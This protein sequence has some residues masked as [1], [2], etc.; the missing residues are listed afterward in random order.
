MEAVIRHVSR[1][2]GSLQRR[3]MLMI[4]KGI[5]RRVDDSGKNQ[6]TQVGLLSKEIRD[7]IENIQQFGLSSSPPPGSEVVVVFPGGSRD[8]GVIVATS[9]HKTRPRDLNEGETV[10]YNSNGDFIKLKS[11]GEI[12]INSGTELNIRA[13][14][15]TI[16]GDLQV[17][18]TAEA[19]QVIAKGV[20]LKTHVHPIPGGPNTQ[21]PV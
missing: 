5:I 3:V 11:T 10:V 4:A 12:E 16:R 13:P 18:G 6:I 15:V 19:Q 20:N 1:L 14:K 17:A 21:P 2:F 9:D 7:Q 8:H